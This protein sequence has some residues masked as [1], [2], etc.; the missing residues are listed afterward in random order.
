MAAAGDAEELTREMLARPD[1]SAPFR[2][3]SRLLEIEADEIA[4][5]GMACHGTTK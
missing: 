5:D 2:R 1:N 3:M 4:H